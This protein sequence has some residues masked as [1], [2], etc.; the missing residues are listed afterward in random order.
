MCSFLADIWSLGCV[1]YEM[2]ARRTAFEAFGLPQLMVRPASWTGGAE[3]REGWEEWRRS[4]REGRRRSWREEG[5]AVRPPVLLLH[6]AP[7]FSPLSH[8]SRIASH[9]LNYS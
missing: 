6:L 9:F 3:G 1:L 7:P 4:G 5:Q 2:A 8:L